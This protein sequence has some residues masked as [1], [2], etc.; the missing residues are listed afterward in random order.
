MNHS[1]HV[2]IVFLIIHPILHIPPLAYSYA[3]R[4]AFELREIGDVSI[5]TCSN[6]SWD[7]NLLDCANNL[8]LYNICVE[9]TENPMKEI[10]NQNTV[11][12]FLVQQLYDLGVRHVFGVPGDY[13]LGFYQYLNE[14]K[15]LMVVNTCD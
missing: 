11:S 4:V 15:K 10:L 2:W 6:R 5:N 13:V 9:Q 14:S 1:L 8:Y 12:S 7:A 3:T